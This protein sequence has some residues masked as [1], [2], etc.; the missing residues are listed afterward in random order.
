MHS[1]VAVA[2][3]W[4]GAVCPGLAAW[5]LPVLCLAAALVFCLGVVIYI[6]HR[7][8]WSAATLPQA[9]KWL[10]AQLAALQASAAGTQ[11][12][13]PANLRQRL[14]LLE[15]SSGPDLGRLVSLLESAL[16]KASSGAA[17]P[18]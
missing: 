18:G 7:D 16:G 1:A 10:S 9:W 8:R 14:E 3:V 4:V 2:L 12:A 13:L 11:A 6:G 5:A 15:S 17:G